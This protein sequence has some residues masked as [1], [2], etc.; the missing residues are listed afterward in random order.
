M[1]EKRSRAQSDIKRRLMPRSGSKMPSAPSV[2]STSLGEG[3]ESN[4]PTAV[5]VWG[6][7]KSF[8][9]SMDHLGGLVK[10]KV[11]SLAIGYHSIVVTEEGEVWV[12]GFNQMSQLGLGAS[13]KEVGRVDEPV[14]LK[15]L[16]GK[17]IVKVFCSSECSAAVSE[18]GEL[19]MWGSVWGSHSL[20]AEPTLIT[21]PGYAKAT[22]VATLLDFA[23]R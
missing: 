16:Q 10:K 14:L 17:G 13:Y 21:L 8:T 3:G 20:L 15:A 7:K 23:I 9:P 11:I 5:F 19:Y 12:W 1:S 4:K 2:A 6:A 22:Q 18:N